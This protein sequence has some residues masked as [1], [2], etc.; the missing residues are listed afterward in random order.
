MRQAVPFFSLLVCLRRLTTHPSACL[1]ALAYLPICQ[2][3][4]CA[5]YPSEPGLS[6]VRQADPAEFKQA[7]PVLAG[8]PVGE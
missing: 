6:I 7:E 8:D 5:V 2:L 3:P 1:P 4:V